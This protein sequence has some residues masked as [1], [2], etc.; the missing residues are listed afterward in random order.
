MLGHFTMYNY[1]RTSKITNSNIDGKGYRT[2]Y[3]KGETYK[4]VKLIDHRHTQ[5]NTIAQTIDLP[6]RNSNISTPRPNIGQHHQARPANKPN[7]NQSTNYTPAR[8]RIS[9]GEMQKQTYQLQPE[10]RRTPWTNSKETPR[11]PHEGRNPVP[12]GSVTPETVRSN[13]AATGSLVG[14]PARMVGLPVAPHWW[15]LRAAAALP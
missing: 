1:L 7:K 11:C 2:H 9:E 13:D 3:L 10:F 4:Q 14:L 8:E 6:K 5:A 12:T 15:I